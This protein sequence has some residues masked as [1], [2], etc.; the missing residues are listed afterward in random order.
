MIG[1]VD[2]YNYFH[3]VSYLLTDKIDSKSCVFLLCAISDLYE[4]L[5]QS[6]PDMKHTICDNNDAI[7]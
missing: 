2:K 4:H 5:E 3:L 1:I 7:F 6:K